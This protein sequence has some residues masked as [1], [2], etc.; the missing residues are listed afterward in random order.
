MSPDVQQKQHLLNIASS[1]HWRDGSSIAFSQQLWLLALVPAIVASVWLFGLNAARIIGLMI[2][3]SVTFD[4]LSERI[5]RSKDRTTNWSSVTLAVLLSFMMPFDSPLWLLATGSFIMVVIGKKLFGGYGAFP[6][7]PAM[8]SFAMLRVSWP[9]YFDYTKS[10]ITLNWPE[11]MI[12]PLRAVKTI[13]GSAAS[14][15]DWHDLLL[16]RQVAG[17]G[18]GLVLYLVVG[19]VLLMAMRQITW[20]IPVAFLAGNFLLAGLLYLI[21]PAQFAPPLFYLLSGGAV[22]AAFFLTTEYTTS[23]VNPLPMFLYGLLG[24]IL[25]MLI[26]AFSNY[27]DGVAFTILIINLCSPLLDKI[28]PKVFGA[29]E[30]K[31]A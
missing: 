2:A 21:D 26:R 8:L 18:E 16:G 28:T 23:P 22:F 11:K 31:N 30:V 6:V 24:G 17:I 10:M 14:L 7:H 12:E 5:V 9:G 29:P 20:H 4:A 27:I 1:P 13:G 3:F 25:L 15:Y 19:G